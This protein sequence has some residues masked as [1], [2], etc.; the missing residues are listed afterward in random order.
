MYYFSHKYSKEKSPLN[1]SFKEEIE[2]LFKTKYK[3]KIEA[4]K[5]QDYFCYE[6]NETGHN[7]HRRRP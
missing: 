2:Q 3:T 5:L 7:L 4:E 1:P 6:F